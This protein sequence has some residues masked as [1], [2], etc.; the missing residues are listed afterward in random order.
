[1]LKG[2]ARVLSRQEVEALLDAPTQ[3]YYSQ[4]RQYLVMRVMA[5][6]GL[7]PCEV[8]GLVPERISF[9]SGRTSV[10]GKGDKKRVLYLKKN[11]V[12]ELLDWMG[13][14]EESE[15]M[16][17]NQSGGRVSGSHLRR[18]VKRHARNV[19]LDNIK[20]ISPYSFRHTFATRLYQ[21]TKDIQI[22]RDA[23]GH[24]LVETTMDYVHVDLPSENELKQALT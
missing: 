23:L 1:M 11:L 12:D 4:H 15:W 7:R 10:I 9:D 17:P 18:G 13:R 8:T 22:V 3:R 6:A 21:K 24:D 20:R 5:E 19:G 14:R 2:H 16:F